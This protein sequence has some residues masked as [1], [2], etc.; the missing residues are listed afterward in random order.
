MHVSSMTAFHLDCEPYFR[1]EY[2]QENGYKLIVYDESLGEMREMNYCVSD[3][4]R[5]LNNVEEICL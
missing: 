4:A 1:K 5:Q 3:R 2:E